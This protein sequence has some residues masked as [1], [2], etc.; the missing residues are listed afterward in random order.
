MNDVNPE[1]HNAE[2]GR[3]DRS[4][5]YRGAKQRVR[6]TFKEWLHA[7]WLDIVTLMLMGAM[8]M[9]VSRRAHHETYYQS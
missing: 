6:P 2:V 3:A 4:I 1:H 5:A 7:T 8:G 9:V